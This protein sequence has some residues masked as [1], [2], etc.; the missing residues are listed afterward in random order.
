MKLIIGI[1]NNDDANHLLNEI[2]RA[3]F[4]ATKLSTSGGFLKT[5][6]ATVLVGVED[7]KTDDVI[8]IFKNCCSRRTQMVSTAPPF[9]GE[10]FINAVPVEVT[11]GG[12]T[13]F[14]VDVEQFM[15][16]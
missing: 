9:L 2:T 16:I 3:S 8:N 12:A 13:L 6:N 4:Q 10:G 1:V 5:G 11:I 15:K 14:V 7:E